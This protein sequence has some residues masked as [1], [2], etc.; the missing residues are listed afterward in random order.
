MGRRFSK[1]ERGRLLGVVSSSGLLLLLLV[2]GRES[3][4]GCTQVE[5]VEDPMELTRFDE[6]TRHFH[7]LDRQCW[8]RYAGHFSKGSMLMVTPWWPGENHILDG[9]SV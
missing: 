5:G 2:F 4:F 7:K 3:P 1:C 6:L 9:H 8:W